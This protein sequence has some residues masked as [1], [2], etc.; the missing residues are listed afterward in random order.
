MIRQ[1]GEIKHFNY[2]KKFGFIINQENS[3]Y[4]F[5]IN[6]FPNDKI[7]TLGAKVEFEMGKDRNGRDKA[8]KIVC[9]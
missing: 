9:E 3:E 7:P 6:D 5:H 1:S 2:E 4:F 8:V